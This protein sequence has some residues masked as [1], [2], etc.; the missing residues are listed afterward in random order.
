MLTR[1]F[2]N[3]ANLIPLTAAAYQRSG[4]A[5]SDLAIEWTLYDSEGEELGTGSSSL[6]EDTDD[7]YEIL[8]PLAV[9]VE[10]VAGEKYYLEIVDTDKG[11]GIRCDCTAEYY[12]GAT[13]AAV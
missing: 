13:P 3:C 11:F 9:A 1:L 4:D 7:E 12:R 10:M 6:V 8:I 2:C 5:A